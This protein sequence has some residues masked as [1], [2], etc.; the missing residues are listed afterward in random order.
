MADNPA[1]ALEQLR[2][3]FAQNANPG[4]M[5]DNLAIA[6]EQLREVFAQNANPEKAFGMSKYMKNLFP[7]VGISSPE[8]KNIVAE[9]REDFKPK[10][11]QEL[12]NWVT[13]LWEMSEREYQ[14]VGM[15][16]LQR[17][18]KLLEIEDIEWFEFLIVTK[19]WWDSID[20]ISGNYLGKFLIKYPEIFE[21][22][23]MRFSQNENMWLNRAAITCQLGYKENT[24]TELLQ[25]AIVPH[26]ESKA[27]FHQKAIGW[28]LRQYGKTNPE[29]VKDF[30][31]LHT[32]K[33]LSRREALRLL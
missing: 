26:L 21:E 12:K 3:V 28:A 4:I 27:F 19:S 31:A 24:N 2:E 14:Y 18:V 30:V 5:A 1:I 15:D 23:V 17:D 7:F 33:P 8:R 32:L 20:L 16:Y 6:L 13:L 29:W 25:M 22:T 10:N 11:A 9:L